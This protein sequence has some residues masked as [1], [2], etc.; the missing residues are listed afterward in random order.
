MSTIHVLLLQPIEPSL[1]TITKQQTIHVLIK[2]RQC[3]ALTY[4]M[5]LFSRLWFQDGESGTSPYMSVPKGGLKSHLDHLPALNLW[6]GVV[7]RLYRSGCQGI[8]SVVAV[9]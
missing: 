8:E 6:V 4:P 5:A 7:A 9:S 2:T 3:L 1:T